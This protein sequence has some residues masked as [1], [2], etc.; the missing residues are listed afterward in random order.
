MFIIEEAKNQAE[1]LLLLEF[2]NKG[3]YY[4]DEDDSNYRVVRSP[5]IFPGKVYKDSTKISGGRLKRNIFDIRKHL[6]G[7]NKKLQ[8]IFLVGYDILDNTVFYELW[9]LPFEGK[10]VVVDNFGKRI[11]NQMLYDNISDAVEEIVDIVSHKDK[12][13]VKKTERELEREASRRKIETTEHYNDLLLIENL[14]E[15]NI[16]SRGMLVDMINADLKEYYATRMSKHNISK[17]W[18][19]IIGREI[20]T[21]TKYIG[22]KSSP[23]KI[24]GKNKEAL[25]VLGYTLNNKI[26][27]EVWLVKDSLT[28]IGKFYV[29]D[30]SSSKIIA[31]NL[32]NMRK[33]F[34][35]IAMKIAVKLEPIDE[36]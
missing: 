23:F 29:F 14:L 8:P 9:Y 34:S 12:V 18:G 10:Y 30:L 26:D 3:H 4:N 16:T 27:V 13:M 20:Q 21:P 24:F 15:Q 19:A 33:A 32:P 6:T 31:K 35:E 25:F 36:D 11:G 17:W 1:D 22:S 7:Y 28:G 5:E 2:K